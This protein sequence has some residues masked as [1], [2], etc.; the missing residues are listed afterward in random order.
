MLQVS[1]TTLMATLNDLNN[2]LKLRTLPFNEVPKVLMVVCTPIYTLQCLVGLK[3]AMY[4]FPMCPWRTTSGVHL[5]NRSSREVFPSL[6]GEG[7]ALNWLN[8]SLDPFR[9]FF[10]LLAACD[11]S[12]A[13]SGVLA[14]ASVWSERHQHGY[15]KNE[16]IFSTIQSLR[17]Y[18]FVTNTL[19]NRALSFWY[20][21]LFVAICVVWLPRHTYI[22]YLVLFL[23]LGTTKWY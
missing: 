22:M 14:L 17:L 21:L 7:Q 16:V 15:Q 6:C 9:W 10:E 23:K 12:C 1:N 5:P 20:F 13:T 3:V 11:R 4:S 18:P 2:C 19:C 8:R